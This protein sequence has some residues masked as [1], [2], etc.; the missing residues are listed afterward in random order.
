MLQLTVFIIILLFSYLFNNPY[1]GLEG[2]KKNL[3]HVIGTWMKK[4]A[5][6]NCT[7]QLK[8]LSK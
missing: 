3:S 2:Y 5:S 6:L 4:Q 7:L 1:D 8:L